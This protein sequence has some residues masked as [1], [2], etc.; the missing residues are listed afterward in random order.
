MT[1]EDDNTR[2][3]LLTVVGMRCAAPVSF[4]DAWLAGLRETR[5]F[6]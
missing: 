2:K 6:A 4:Q 1:A 5:A 3:Y